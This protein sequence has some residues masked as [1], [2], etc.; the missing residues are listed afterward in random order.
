[1][2]KITVN[3]DDRLVTPSNVDYLIG[4]EYVPSTVTRVVFTLPDNF[5]GKLG[6][7]FYQADLRGLSITATYE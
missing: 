7:V 3:R 4:G 1:M 5:D 6:L 2:L